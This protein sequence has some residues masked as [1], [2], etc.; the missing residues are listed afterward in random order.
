MSETDG[1]I[2]VSAEIPGVSEKDID[3]TISADGTSLSIRGEKKLAKNKQEKKQEK[4]DYYCAER[5]Y[6]EFRRTVALPTEVD[7]DEVEAKFHNGVLEIVLTK[8]DA[9]SKVKHIAVKAS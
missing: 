5:A 4:K 6:G 3:L 9:S 7:P 1:H 8:A 2:E